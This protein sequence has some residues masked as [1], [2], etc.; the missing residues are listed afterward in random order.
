MKIIGLEGMDSQELNSQLQQGARF[1]IYF[2]CISIIVMTFR[3]P[4]NI[5][6]VRAGE[7]AAVKGLGFSL[8]SLLLGWWGIPWGPIYTMHSLAT[9][10]GGGKDV[11]QEVV[12]DLMHQAG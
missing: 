2:Y 5:Y 3:R 8:I 9:N 10:F 12:A 6:F 4:S 11:T 7:N 1:V